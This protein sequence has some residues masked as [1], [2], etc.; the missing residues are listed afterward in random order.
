MHI[1]FQISGKFSHW[2]R[3]YFFIAMQ[4][5]VFCFCTISIRSV[6]ASENDINKQ[7]KDL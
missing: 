6:D 3:K 4:L 7:T 1:H 2:F 5:F